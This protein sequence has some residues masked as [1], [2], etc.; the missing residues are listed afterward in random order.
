MTVDYWELNKVT[1]LL[2]V[3]VP[4]IAH[5]MEYLT[6]MLGRYYYIVDLANSFFSTAIIPRRA[7]GLPGVATGYLH[8]LTVMAW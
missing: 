8:S 4:N 5:V 1:P 7:R 6:L 3:A 2:H